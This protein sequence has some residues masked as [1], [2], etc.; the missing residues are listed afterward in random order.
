MSVIVADSLLAIEDWI[1]YQKN[2]ALATF[3]IDRDT[4]KVN[5]ERASGN[6]SDIMLLKEIESPDFKD[7]LCKSQ[8]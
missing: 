5:V 7:L 1:L 2:G 4:L 3:S 6:F 8:V